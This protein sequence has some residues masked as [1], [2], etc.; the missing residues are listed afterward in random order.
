[1]RKIFISAGHSNASGRDRGASGNG[2]IEGELTVELRNLV[3][4]ELRKLGVSPT[5]DKDN[6]ILS[7]SI[8]FFK[9]LTSNSCIVLDIHWNA[10]TP[11]A[12][13][14]ETLIPLEH[15]DFELRLA[16]ALSKVVAET[17]G[18]PLRGITKGHKGVKTEADSH[19]GRLGWMRLTGENVLMEICFISNPTEMI[20]YQERKNIIAKEIAN[21]L[22][23]FA[24]GKRQQTHTVVSGETLTSISR[25][26]G[27]TV[28]Q[29]R[30]LN[31]LTTDSLRVGQ[32]L[33]VK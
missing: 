4:L 23:D 1:M 5:V 30:T 26:H 32:I 21:V 14:T 25:I 22:F 10:A 17:M 3:T 15:T 13:G 2:F 6:S 16:A 7:E 12:T 33:I 9:N 27:T 18:I 31:N 8:N 24:G 29:L 19:H 20:T 28:S 11:K